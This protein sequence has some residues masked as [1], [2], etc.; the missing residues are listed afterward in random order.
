MDRSNHHKANPYLMTRSLIPENQE[1][2]IQFIKTDI[3]DHKLFY[4]R[5]HF[6]YPT[7][8]YSNY[9][10]PIN[11]MVSTP[12][13]LSM[14]DILQ[15]PSKT[16]PVVL[17]CSGDKRNLFKPKVFGEQWE[18]GAISQGYWKGVPLRSLLELSGIRE[19]AKEIVVE[20]Y[21]FGDRTDLNK[22]FTYARSLPIEKALHP[23]TIIAYEYNNQPIPFK[24]GYPLRL[25]VPQWYAMAS[26]KWIK[27][28]RVISSHFEGPFQSIDYMYYPNKEN[29]KD[30][31]P[32]TTVNV[33]STI[34]KPL[35]MEILN[36]GKHL[37]KGIA[38]SGKGFITNLEISVD[39]GG[40]WKNAKLEP[41]RRGGYAWQSWSYEWTVSK[42][43]NYMIMSKATD[44]YGRIQPTVPFWNKKG[45]GYNAIDKIK[46]KV[47]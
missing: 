22:V 18:K 33:N 1:T 46:V 3:V 40:T 39:G 37:I 16:I 23:D 26:V 19:G 36:T 11:G 5:N 15:F 4:R 14:Q 35:D 12:I 8:S 34:Q 42:K 32:V 7:L 44:S 30:A 38:W 43:G 6:P 17:E 31:F 24:H 2:P 20:G 47:E 9:Y 25:I 28:I 21:D 41:A 13:L 10:L 45:Y 27:Q 29:N